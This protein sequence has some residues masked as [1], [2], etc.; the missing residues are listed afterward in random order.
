M[1]ICFPGG[2]L[3]VSFFFLSMEPVFPPFLLSSFPSSLPPTPLSSF[4]GEAQFWAFGASVFVAHLCAGLS[5]DK[6]ESEQEA[7]PGA[8]GCSRALGLQ[9]A[10]VPTEPHTRTEAWNGAGMLPRAPGHCLEG[11]TQGD[12]KNRVPALGVTG[13]ERRNSGSTQQG[14]GL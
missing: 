7:E 6:C 3:K 12:R 10:V 14:A 9:K 5:S 4:N 13:G 8:R 1:F 11:K 2:S